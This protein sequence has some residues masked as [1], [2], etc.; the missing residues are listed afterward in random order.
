MKKASRGMKY[1]RRGAGICS[2]RSVE[3]GR[4][5]EVIIPAKVLLKGSV[6]EIDNYAF[7]NSSHV[8]GVVIPEGVVAIGEFAF[9][10]CKNLEYI[11]LP[12]SLQTIGRGAFMH[13]EKLKSIVLPKAISSISDEAFACCYSL[14]RIDLTHVQAIGKYAFAECDSLKDIRTGECIKE[15]DASSFRGS[16][17][18][19]HH[20]NWK[21]G[22]LYLGKWVI[23]CNGSAE[24]YTVKRDTV[25]IVSDVFDNEWHIKRTRNPE[26]DDAL[27]W[28]HAALECP[29]MMLPDLSH[30]PEYFEEI[31]PAKIKYEGTAADWGRIIKLRGVKRIPVLVRCEDGVRESYL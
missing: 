7:R 20:A 16:G 25:G 15:I 24:E 3:G 23:G 17:Y 28:F 8:Q 13:C 22:L 11:V 18:Y 21:N 2:L 14:E 6:T 30:I 26:Y 27:H 31:L 4:D 10:D 19:K 9:E 12:Q 1:T 29:N 5:A